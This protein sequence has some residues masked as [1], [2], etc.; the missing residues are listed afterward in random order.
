M[1]LE[2]GLKYEAFEVLEKALLPGEVHAPFVFSHLVFFHEPLGTQ[3]SASVADDDIQD[4]VVPPA[5]LM[6]LIME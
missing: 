3:D 4:D 2:V 6:R 5:F 1:L